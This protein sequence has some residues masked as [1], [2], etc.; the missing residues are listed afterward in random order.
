MPA[1]SKKVSVPFYAAFPF[2]APFP[3]ANLPLD[4]L[5]SPARRVGM[6]ILIASLAA[7]LVLTACGE[8]GKSDV[9]KT[10]RKAKTAATSGPAGVPATL[11]KRLDLASCLAEDM[12][13]DEAQS[14]R[15]PSFALLSLDYMG[16][17]CAAHGGTLKAHVPSE[18]WSLDVD[19][20]A[21]AEILIDLIGNFDCE[22]APGAF[23]CGST[24]CPFLLY[25]K[26]G[27]SWAEIGAF[28]ADD[29][30]GIEVLPAK[31]GAYATLR[32][33]CQ[34]QQ[35]CSELVHYEWNGKTYARTWIDY[36]GHAVDVAA[37]GTLKTLTQDSAV[38]DA[39]GGKKAQALDEYP[40]GTS[41]LVIGTAR[42]GPYTFVSPCNACRR[43]F[44]ETA[45]LAK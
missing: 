34:G 19:G 44:V 27:D 40:V 9:T 14:S 17:Q 11:T 26:R 38:Y 23:A 35:P 37:Q 5:L 36:K 12:T 2:F 7:L 43:G 31:E 33:G 8:S 30:P 18:A 24:G 32:G 45:L 1:P 29:G 28:N 25:K 6:R 13:E 10:Q 16:K 20:D 15:C 22:G 41:M 4:R 42:E 21:S 3:L 39:P